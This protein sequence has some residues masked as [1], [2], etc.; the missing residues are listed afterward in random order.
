MDNIKKQAS[1]RSAKSDNSNVTTPKGPG[2]SKAVS[3]QLLDAE[4]MNAKYNQFKTEFDDNLL[5]LR[6]GYNRRICKLLISS[7]SELY[8][9]RILIIFSEIGER[10]LLSELDLIYWYTAINAYLDDNIQ[11][12]N[13]KLNTLKIQSNTNIIPPYSDWKESEL[14]KVLILCG[15]LAKKQNLKILKNEKSFLKY[16][17]SEIIKDMETQI[18]C[19]E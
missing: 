1:L 18:K 6:Q 14:E 2:M 17:S 4:T 16:S 7:F 3:Q 19:V 11:F 15:M 9:F 5:P 8:K 12:Y 10:L 13:S